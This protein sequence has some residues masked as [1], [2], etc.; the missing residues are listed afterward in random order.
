MRTA[1]ATFAQPLQPSRRVGLAGFL[2]D[3]FCGGFG[4]LLSGIV[5][6]R[7]G[8]RATMCVWALLNS[9]HQ[10]RLTENGNVVGEVTFDETLELV[11][12]GGVFGGLLAGFA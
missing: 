7:L 10:D 4:G 6:F 9:E 2:R 1:P 11:L 8:G 3:S 5:C 12:F